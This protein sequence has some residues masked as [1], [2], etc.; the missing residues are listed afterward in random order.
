MVSLEL[1]G[2]LFWVVAMMLGFIVVAVAVVYS[3]RVWSSDPERRAIGGG[4]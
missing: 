1:T 4:S 2:Q 3:Y